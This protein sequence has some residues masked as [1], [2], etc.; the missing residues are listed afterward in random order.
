MADTLEISM[1][2][3]ATVE[4]LLRLAQLDAGQATFHYEKVRLVELVN[5]CWRPFSQAAGSRKLVF[6][7]RVPTDLVC[8]S[9]R[10][11][12]TTI[13]GNLLENCAEY[14]DDRG[15]VWVEG[16]RHGK[17]VEIRIANSGCQLQEE[18]VDRIFDRFWRADSARCGTGLH[19]GLGLALVR[20]ITTALNGLVEAQLAPPDILR[21]IVTLPQDR[22][23]LEKPASAEP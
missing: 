11:S 16:A 17:D 10:H 3:Q 8:E 2:L 12:L 9:D 14:A 21:V 5:D 22:S 7:N 13:L 19:C 6:A 1:R 20:R 18:D 23:D 4:N 15:H